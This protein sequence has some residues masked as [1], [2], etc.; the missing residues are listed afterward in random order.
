MSDAPVIEAVRN[1]ETERYSELVDRYQNMVYGIA[2]SRL[3]D[4]TLCEDAAQETF[5]KAFRYLRALRNPE[6]FGAWLGRIARNVSTSMLRRHKRELAR[7]ERWRLEQPASEEVA[8]EGDEAKS[9][10]ETLRRTVSSLPST[11]RECLVLFYI[12]GKSVREASTALGISET[13]MKTRL[14]RARTVLRGKLEERLESSLADLEPRK[15][16]KTGVMAL[17]PATSLTV[18]GGSSSTA[19]AAL[20]S[21]PWMLLLWF[22]LFQGVVAAAFHGWLGKLEAD[23]L[24]PGTGR[25]FRKTVIRGNVVA[26]VLV[27]VPTLLISITV[28]AR[29]GPVFLF[30]LLIPLCAFGTWQTARFLRVNRSPFAYGQVLA[31]AT[32]LV[33]SVLMGFCHAPFWTFF[34]ALLVLNITL[35]H[36]NKTAPIRHDY[37]LFLR[38]ARGLLGA[39]EHVE[40]RPVTQTQALAFIRYLGD[41]FL[42]RD[43]RIT[44]TG[45]VLFLPPVKMSATQFFGVTGV[46]SRIRIDFDG[47]CETQLGARDL[48]DLRK[49][50]ESNVVDPAALEN[51]VAD[52][53]ATALG[54]FLGGRADEAE[55]LLQPE[56]DASVFVRPPAESRAHKVRGALAIG[57]AVVMLTVMLTTGAFTGGRQPH[58]PRTISREMA[59]AEI[60]EWAESGRGEFSIL[61]RAQ[62][63]PPMAFFG[64]EV[65][66]RYKSAVV[67]YLTNGNR[68]N[69]P[70]RVRAAL[71]QPRALY[72]VISSGVLTK[73]ELADIG[74]SPESVRAA[75]EAL[76]SDAIQKM[77]DA[78]RGEVR[79]Q[80]GNYHFVEMDR[81][82]WR[83]ACLREF[84]CLDFVDGD[85]LVAYIVEHQVKP[86][87]PL[88]DGYAP[89]DVAKADGLFHF[90]WCDMSM[91][92]G[93]LW[94]LQTL[95]ALDRIDQLACT[96]GIMRFHQGRGRFQSDVRESNILINPNEECTYLAM[97]SL[98]ILGALDRV[99]DLAK[100]RFEPK[101]SVRERNGETER[102]VVTNEG[103][104]S[105][106][107]QLRLEELR[108]GLGLD[109]LREPQIVRAPKPVPAPREL[110][111]RPEPAIV[112]RK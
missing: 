31:S 105:W 91:T 104:A 88:R 47:Q 79:A 49:L 94:A 40:P 27:T 81:I 54:L 72:N 96:R 85:R 38:Q 45:V 19:V 73:Q 17:L 5:V 71:S 60:D 36:T 35:Y 24:A 77:N 29:L 22:G 107:R 30:R 6:K 64:P 48:R 58:W 44:N 112:H 101:T 86:G 3:G 61:L 20:L 32:F 57:A 10:S 76:G 39:P 21:V 25:G 16:F 43:Y 68:K 15:G 14:H 109:G 42:L 51:A 2:W 70:E 82:A 80:G 13:A 84:D 18:G 56:G 106:A 28:T 99:P 103:V 9:L 63:H 93:A 7:R 41:R 78:S 4:A 90:G 102:G 53:A 87:W 67:G 65:G 11:H 12:E 75:L 111:A 92:R 97:E 100:W 69:I 62:A 34:A 98:A 59:L 23:N 1:G 50:S 52:V 74:F 46:N 37:N 33:V 26:L 83:L 8:P 89:V 55:S 95:D 66:E 110:R 108:D